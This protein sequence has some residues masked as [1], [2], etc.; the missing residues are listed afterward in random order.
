M[1]HTKFLNPHA[2]RGKIRMSNTKSLNPPAARTE[3]AEHA[4]A[5]ASQFLMRYGLVVVVAWIGVLKYF[6]YEAAAI[7]P[8]IAHSPPLSWLYDIFNVHTLGYALGSRRSSRLCS[9]RSG[10][11]GHG[12]RPSAARSPCCSSAARS[13]SCSPHPESS[14][15]DWA[16]VGAAGPVPGQGHCA[17]RCRPVDAGRLARRPPADPAC[18]IGTQRDGGPLSCVQGRDGREGTHA[19]CRRHH[20]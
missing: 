1:S 15:A 3:T 6:P 5:I 10:R 8:L 17:A 19:R 4:V 7:Q 20:R 12:S 11:S 2:V 13:A 18:L 9:S 14:Q 16:A